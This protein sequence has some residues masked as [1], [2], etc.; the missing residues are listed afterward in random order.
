MSFKKKLLAGFIIICAALIS[1]S[2]FAVYSL[3][4]VVKEYQLLVDQSVPK[5]GDISGLRARAAQ[6]RADSLKLTL[7]ADNKEESAEALKDL[8]KAL[9]RYKEIQEEYESKNFFSD[10]EKE[11]FTKIKTNAE[12]VT[13]TG[14][15]VVL[16]FKSNDADRVKKMSDAL[17][18]VEGK[19]IEHQKS[20]LDLDDYIVE[21]SAAWSKG[22]LDFSA[23]AKKTLIFI[24]ILVAILSIA[25]SYLYVDKISKML[26]NVAENILSSSNSVSVNADQVNEASQ[27]L[28]SSTNEQAASLQ[29]TVSATNE[30]MA[31]IQ[32]T[33]DNTEH[34]LKKAKSSQGNS[35][36]GQQAVAEML[37]A[38]NDISD[39]NKKIDSEIERSNIEMK[40][41]VSMI[42][43]IAEKTKIINEIV[44][45][46]KLLS[47]NA[48]V[49]AARAGESGKGFAVVAEEVSKLAAV[50][51]KAADEIGELLTKSNLRV[52][53]IITKTEKSVSSLMKESESKI[54]GG[55]LRAKKCQNSLRAIDEDINDMLSMSEQITTATR[56]Q[57]QG[58]SE[59]N[60]ALEQIGLA[61]N[62]NA[63]ASR[64][65]SLAASELQA[66][67]VKAS[68]AANSLFALIR[69]A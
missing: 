47:F 65:C 33:S 4:N 20:L 27:N 10:L 8:E 36:Q 37:G 55:V 61:T 45:Q 57:S 68:N 59:I 67:A 16:M 13:K 7:F 17:L 15:E 52:E 32:T 46:T 40:E 63:D 50:S 35:E 43:N 38:I 53:E 25:M 19:A 54:E 30:V 64:K 3:E 56:E 41:I 14:D 66:E 62:Q 26:T 42:N 51:G 58:V 60:T 69:G 23:K 39:A 22:A 48:S 29:E 34:S 24:S 6:I 21:V 11:K 49:E 31:M 18:A 1:I 44:F 28:S 5:F 2:F 9:S 12:S